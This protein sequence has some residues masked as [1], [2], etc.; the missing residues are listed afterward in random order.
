MGK[1]FYIMGKSA[2]GKDTIY[3]ELLSRTELKLR[4]IVLYTTRPIRA[5]ETDGV[6]YHF[7]T[8]DI[9][10][11]MQAEG[12]VIELRTYDTVQG[13]WHYF[14]ADSDSMDME[15]FNYLALG[16]LVSYEKMRD[17]YGADRVVPLYIEVEDGKRLER[18]M[19]REKKQ[20]VPDYVEMCRRFL[21]DQEDFSEKNI[22]RAGITRRFPNNDDREICMDE[23]ADYI[24]ARL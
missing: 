7:V 1:I 18:A 20:E 22:A 12:K 5:K 17:Y 16:T 14:T 19:K 15:Q 3:A 6:E 4:P 9:L 11:K 23:L 21:A 2:S 13:P 8:L 24:K 10:Q